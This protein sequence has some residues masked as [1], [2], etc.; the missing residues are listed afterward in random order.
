M[1]FLFSVLSFISVQK[2]SQ[3]PPLFKRGRLAHSRATTSAARTLQGNSHVEQQITNKASAKRG[4]LWFSC[5]QHHVKPVCRVLGLIKIIEGALIEGKL[6]KKT[7]VYLFYD[8]C[9][10]SVI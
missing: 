6:K 3:T 1:D 10:N 8:S 5:L 7:C 2:S 4:G 9:I